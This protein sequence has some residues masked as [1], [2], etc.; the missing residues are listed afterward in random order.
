MCV[1]VVVYLCPFRCLSSSR[2]GY[3]GDFGGTFVYVYLYDCV[4]VS[5]LALLVIGIGLPLFRNFGRTFV[6]MCAFARM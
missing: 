2:H 6:C 4:I 5:F 3:L 1:C